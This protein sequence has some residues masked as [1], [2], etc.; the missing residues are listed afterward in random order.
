LTPRAKKAVDAPG[1][2]RVPRAFRKVLVAN[3]AEIAVRVCRTLREMGIPSVAV[4]SDADRGALHA[5]SADEAVCI[6][7]PAPS[8]SYLNAAAILEAARTTGADAIHPGYG[9]LSQSAAFAR[10]CAEAGVTFIGPSPESMEILGDKASSRRTAQR[11]GVPTIPGVEGVAR[12]EDALREAERIGYPVLLKAVG[13]GG[14]RGMRRAADP[15]ELRAA[16]DSARREAKTAFGDERLFLEKLVHPARHVEIQIV[17][18]GTDAIAIGER[19]CSL[20]RRYQK[21][22]EESPCAALSDAT[23][24]AMESAAVALAREARYAGAGTVEF[25]LGPDGSFYFLEVNTRLQVEHPV[26]EMR[27]GLDLVR[28]QIEIAAG[29]K[30]PAQPALRGHAIEARLNAEDPYHGYLPQTGR[31]LLLAW[32]AGD[33]VRVDAG[34]APRQEIHAHYDSLLAKVIAHGATREDARRRLVAALESLV[35]L[36]VTTN[37]PFLLQL[38]EH[39]AFT[40]A[41]TFTHTLESAEWSAPTSLPDG[42]LAAAAVALHAPSGSGRGDARDEADRYSPWLRLGGWGRGGAR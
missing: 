20:Q 22:I 39:E 21:V 31:A 11:C 34:I 33:G 15:D 5:R 30:V 42:V 41:E 19:E 8:D 2:A 3:R 28:A 4:Y 14:G 9:F 12:A 40:R 6:G 16:F 26:T 32:P 25:L 35:L 13:G 23:R 18:D 1:A 17:G 37:Q 10:A 7:A 36:G 24:A 27:S 29:G 38:L